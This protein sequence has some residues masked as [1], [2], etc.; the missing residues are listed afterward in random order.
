M[1]SDERSGINQEVL[2]QTKAQIRA[3]VGEIVQYSKSDLGPDEFYP[4]VLH[5]IVQALAAVGGAVWTFDEA[6][7]L[8]LT[9]Q[10]QVSDTLLAP[11]SED[12]VRHHRLLE[13]VAASRQPQLIPPLSGMT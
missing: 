13:Y 10:E 7:S 8:K 6:R 4:A 9:Y 1:S 12:A 5:R 3:L 11:Q 2:E